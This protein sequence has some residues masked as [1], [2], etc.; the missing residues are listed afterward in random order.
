MA[1]RL[2]VTQ[3]FDRIDA[4]GFTCG[5][6]SREQTDEAENNRCRKHCCEGHNGPAE[7][8]H[9]T[10]LRGNKP[11]AAHNTVRKQD[12]DESADK[13]E[14]EGLKTELREDVPALRTHCHFDPN[15]S[16]TFLDDHVHH[17]CYADSGDKK[18]QKAHAKKKYLNSE[19]N[20]P[21][22]FFSF[23]EIPD[24]Q[25]P[26]VFLVKSVLPAEH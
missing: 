13:S 1:G 5:K 24:A 4:C 16:R 3:R 12:A 21:A 26:F 19:R 7:E 10:V 6:E 25:R 8:L 17:V 23:D 2:F 9:R 14:K 11:H 22:D 15:F 20:L 18:G